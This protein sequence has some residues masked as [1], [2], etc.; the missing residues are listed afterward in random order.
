MEPPTGAA[1][2]LSWRQTPESNESLRMAAAPTNRRRPKLLQILARCCGKLWFG[3]DLTLL[4]AGYFIIFGLAGLLGFG[5]PLEKAA[6]APDPEAIAWSPPETGH[7][8][9]R[10]GAGNPMVPRVIE[11]AAHSLSATFLAVAGGATVGL[12]FASLVALTIRDRGYRLLTGLAGGI[13]CVPAVVLL[14]MAFMGVGAGFWVTAILFGVVIAVFTA[15]RTARA[16]FDLELEGDVLAS[17]GL[18]YSRSRLLRENMISRLLP[19]A[20]AWM[21]SL[22]PAVL[23]AVAALSYVGFGLAK[24][25]P[26]LGRLIAEGRVVMFEAPWLVLY[27][28]M[29]LWGL[30]VVLSILGWAVRRTARARVVDPIF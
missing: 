25:T 2:K 15:G 18:G 26:G 23:L 28:G 11:A 20:M 5:W 17:R 29:V 12:L 10:D 9:G 13:A 1:G 30:A 22:F 7:W 3:W 24:E 16:L 4:V 6:S 21:A 8:M 19:G 27:P 14:L